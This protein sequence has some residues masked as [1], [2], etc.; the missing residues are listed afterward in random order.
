MV[1]GYLLVMY[2]SLTVARAWLLLCAL[3]SLAGSASLLPTALARGDLSVTAYYAVWVASM[4]L[5]SVWLVRR[6]ITARRP[7]GVTAADGSR[8]GAKEPAEADLDNLVGIDEHGN[9]VY[10]VTDL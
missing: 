4:L 6:M 8:F 7:T 2:T 1:C 3:A 5:W 9:P 10:R